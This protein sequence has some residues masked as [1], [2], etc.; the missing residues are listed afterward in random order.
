MTPHR[1]AM[2]QCE[3]GTR[4]ECHSYHYA[5]FMDDCDPMV[6]KEVWPT[7]YQFH[8]NLNHPN[9]FANCERIDGFEI[10]TVWDCQSLERAE[11]FSRYVDRSPRVCATL[12]EATEGVDAVF[13]ADGGGDGSEHLAW[14][15]PI[16]EKGL[17]VFVDKP[18]AATHADA[19]AMV[20]LA[21]EADTPLLS[22]SILGFVPEVAIFKASWGR[23]PEPG[24]A[25]VKGVGPANGAVVHGLAL[26][27]GLFGAGV[28]WVECSGDMPR[29]I[30]HMHYHNGLQVVLLNTAYGTFDWFRCEVWSRTNRTNPPKKMYAQSD[31]IGDPEYLPGSAVIV[32]LFKQMLDTGQ[33]PI[34]YDGP[35][36]LAALL[37]AGLEAHQTRQRVFLSDVVK[38]SQ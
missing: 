17:P 38:R 16:L 36:E 28:E 30:M 35:V 22:A 11:T 15:K 20:D 29:E 4:D 32:R 31:T 14:V 7:S 19:R 33:P 27:Q 25:V 1:I 26:M 13:L 18:F 24:L 2:L 3:R 37:E 8:T 9:E 10:V 34:A 23:I 21:V 5:P 6:L 12:E